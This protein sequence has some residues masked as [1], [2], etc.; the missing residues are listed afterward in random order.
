[1]CKLFSGKPVQEMYWMHRTEAFTGCLMVL[2]SPGLLVLLN[3]ETGTQLWRKSFHDH[4][5]SFALDPFN[6]HN[7]A[8]NN[9]SASYLQ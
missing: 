5:V 2:H 7:M 9:A 1:M 4:L 3:A 6:A 8:G